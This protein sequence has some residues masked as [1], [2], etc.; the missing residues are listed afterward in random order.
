[1]NLRARLL[2]VFLPLTVAPALVFGVVQWWT[3][4][5]IE[6][7]EQRG[8]DRTEE[9]ESVVAGQLRTMHGLLER[10]I[11]SGQLEVAHRIADVLDAEI[12][13]RVLLARV[14]AGSELTRRAAAPG[15]HDDGLWLRRM[16][17]L[18]R[19]AGLAE[20]A[21]LDGDGFEIHA[22]GGRVRL[23][24]TGPPVG[25]AP[26]VNR[27]PDE[28]TR[29]WWRARRAEP[30]ATVSVHSGPNPDLPDTMTSL[31]V[32]HSVAPGD[33]DASIG[34]RDRTPV[35]K[36][37]VPFGD[38]VE[39]AA[40]LHE[41]GAHLVVLTA[42][43][44]TLHSGHPAASVA[45]ASA[46]REVAHRHGLIV[47]Y[48]ATSA[49]AA[50]ARRRLESIEDRILQFPVELAAEA[51]AFAGQTRRMELWVAA[52]ALVGAL[53]T[54][55]FVAW[56]SRDIS[57]PVTALSRLARTIAR[58]DLDTPIHVRGV[59]EVAELGDDLDR[60][61]RRLQVQMSAL[62]RANNDMK[63]AMEIKS[64]FLA[65]M[66]HEI[67][68]PMNGVLGMTELLLGT[69]LDHEQRQYAETVHGSGETLMRV[70]NDILDL[71][72]IEA[73][74]MSIE[75]VRFPLRASIEETA[76][77]MA[78][79]A[80]EKDLDLVAVLDPGLA[81]VALGDPTRLRQVLGNLVSNAIKFTQAGE[82]V[83]RVSESRPTDEALE[84][85]FDVS[86]TGV[87]ISAEQQQSLF[88]PF[89]QVDASTTR[90]YGGTGL[91]LAIS[92]QLVERMNGGIGVQSEPGRGSTFTFTVRLGLPGDHTDPA[93]VL[94]PD[95]ASRR[96]LICDDNAT[97]RQQLSFE[98]LPCGVHVDIVPDC[99]AARPFVQRAIDEDEAYDV[100][101]AD[102]PL[103]SRDDALCR[104]FRKLTEATGATV[105]ALVPLGQPWD[106]G[107]AR[108]AG[109]AGMIAKPVKRHEL[110]H[111]LSDVFDENAAPVA[112]T[113]ATSEDTMPLPEGAVLVAE[114][115]PVNQQLIH[116]L[117]QKVGID[118]VT[119][120]ENGQLALDALCTRDFALVLMDMQM[121]VVD[122]LTATH[123][124]RESGSGVRD[125]RIPV[126]A[127]TANAMNGDR[128]RCLAAG[129]DDYMAKPVRLATLREVLRRHL[130]PSVAS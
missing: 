4:G 79:R 7:F 104:E 36:V 3:L 102:W 32:A 74:K 92:K 55:G 35:V 24:G 25:T 70:I 98:L 9:A 72:K 115:N 34:S 96:M 11:Q 85:R 100:I 124:I 22:V 94:C 42:A 78:L 88:R 15:T 46:S 68:T 112:S 116:R 6:R 64:Q 31:V 107:E 82:V 65:N 59:N 127:L 66:S 103:V 5:E 71:S 49:R 47:E 38:L 60:M 13:A 23:P 121:P 99:E 130:R 57:R 108:E 90:R 20:I 54:A 101:L 1:M 97:V 45:P 18:V 58:G 117:L 81:S 39:R 73:G 110:Y 77:L 106:A 44:D 8:I 19:Q 87:G 93:P 30:S 17:T 105:L 69:E 126:V 123:R 56:I 109:V 95:G 80:H 14:I 53:L 89:T 40:D 75:T 16:R 52:M 76:D 118:D 128:E 129:M 26:L 33:P 48:H 43:G 10:E 122:G 83:I 125:P 119:V 113:P 67:R 114:D 28:S 91:G 21:L 50:E 63:R 61:R 120:V 37:V 12:E 111:R 86:D 29:P 2:S 27:S 51:R 84:L 62:Q 41:P